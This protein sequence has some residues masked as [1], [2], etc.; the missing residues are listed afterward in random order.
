LAAL[1][2]ATNG[3]SAVMANSEAMVAAFVNVSGGQPREPLGY[4]VIAD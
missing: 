4:L 1:V 3:T 2:H